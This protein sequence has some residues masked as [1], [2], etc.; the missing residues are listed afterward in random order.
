MDSRIFFWVLQLFVFYLTNA[1]SEKCLKNS[2]QPDCKSSTMT[3]YR[4]VANYNDSQLQ[5]AGCTKKKI[6]LMIRHGTRLPARKFI[7]PMTEILPDIQ[8]QIIKNYQNGKSKLSA[9]FIEKLE[10]WTI[11]LKEAEAMNLAEEGQNELIDLAERMQARLPELFPDDYEKNLFRFK[12]TATQ[13]TELS[14]KSFVMGLFG[15]HQSKKVVFEQPEKKDPILRFYKKCKKWQ[16]EVHDNPKTQKERDLFIQSNYVQKV[17]K[18]VSKQIGLKLDYAHVRLIY[19]MC[20]FETAF[21]QAENSPWCD[22]LSINDLNVLEYAEDL[23]YYWK[24][25]YGYKLNYEQACPALHDMFT[26]F[27]KEDETLV[28]AYFSHSGT[29]LKILSILGIAQDEKVLTHDTFPINSSRNWRSSLID[30]FASNIAF[31][32]YDCDKQ[33]PSILVLHQERPAQ[34]PGCPEE[35]LCPVSIMKDIFPAAAKDC[36]FDVVCE[37]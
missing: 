24:D 6:W 33:G 27:D 3:P 28:T 32:L 22:L 5:F 17:V 10:R 34:I 9:D 26:F 36:K 12:Y 13:R 19:M 25:S 29:I 30:A 18:D 8:K 7:K 23:K 16:K 1:S 2:N 35:G 11:N 20:G 37:N 14:A 15:Q 31:V 21:N 4:F